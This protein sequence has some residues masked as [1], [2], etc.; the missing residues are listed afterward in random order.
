MVSV[1]SQPAIKWFTPS[2]L[3]GRASIFKRDH[4]G[5]TVGQPAI[6]RFST[7]LFMEEFL[8]LTA[9][10]PERLAEWLARNETW[11]DPMPTPDTAR[12]LRL[13]ETVSHAPARQGEKQGPM[14]VFQEPVRTSEPLKLYQPVHQRHYLVAATLACQQSGLPDRIVDRAK[15]EQVSFVIRRIAPQD[16]ASPH[17]QEYA[18]VA[19]DGG[20]LWRRIPAE[21]TQSVEPGEERLPLFPVAYRRCECARQLL[22]GSIPVGRRE[23]YLATPGWD[24]PATTAAGIKPTPAQRVRALFDAEVAA[25]WKALLEKAQVFEESFL[26]AATP[27]DDTERAQQLAD[28]AAAQRA[29]HEQIQTGSWYVCLDFARFLEKYLP[30][31][32]SNIAQGGG[33]AGLN[34]A[35]RRLAQALRDTALQTGLRDSLLGAYGGLGYTLAPTLASALI[36]ARAR[37]EQLEATETPLDLRLRATQAGN[38]WPDALFPLAHP[39]IKRSGNALQ[40]DHGLFGLLPRLSSSTSAAAQS[41]LPLDQKLDQVDALSELVESALPPGLTQAPEFD[42]VEPPAPGGEAWFVIR[43]VYERPRCRPAPQVIVSAPT[44]AF[45]MAPFFDPDAPARAIR[46]PMPLD[47]SPAGLR[48]FKKNT[49]FMISD[50]L[51]GQLGRIKKTTLGDLVLSVLPWPFHKDLP[52]VG[53]GG[54]CKKGGVGF[55][56]FC[57]LSIPIVTLCAMILMIIMVALFDIFFRWL[58]YLFVCLPIPGL[59]GKKS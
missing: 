21:R 16:I 30:S 34:E 22:A 53:A 32:W 24:R 10:Y 43:C 17:R 31:L 13:L 36:S 7:D 57:S 8:S 56:M 5:G 19:E 58:P 52:N 18:F 23:A 9:A 12:Q 44:Q 11:R 59:K 38:D 26:G 51:C 50:M 55:G 48:K 20:F 37:G 46:I 15:D 1:V 42:A 39:A 49:T 3:L 47:I 54:S 6:L 40:R 4:G 14:P 2:P 45:Q 33:A 29:L 35:Q 41:S 27:G 28:F 25:P